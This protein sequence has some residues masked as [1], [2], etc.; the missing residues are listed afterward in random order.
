M[1]EKCASVIPKRG[2]LIRD[3]FDYIPELR[4]K[5]IT[6]RKV[7]VCQENVTLQE[8]IYIVDRNFKSTNMSQ[9]MASHNRVTFIMIDSLY[10]KGQSRIFIK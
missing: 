8:I 10:L 7:F 9:E 3:I 6:Q 5:I 4:R 1:T 2:D